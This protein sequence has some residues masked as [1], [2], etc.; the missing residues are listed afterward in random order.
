MKGKWT[1]LDIKKRN[2]YIAPFLKEQDLPWWY[3][4]LSLERQTSQHLSWVG[5]FQLEAQL[6]KGRV[7][8]GERS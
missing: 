3:T 8:R 4:V 1:G 6:A 5:H 7:Q 2:S